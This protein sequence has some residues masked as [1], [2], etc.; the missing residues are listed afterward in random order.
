MAQFTV[1]RNKN[2]QTR[3]AIPFLLDIQN[4]LLDGLETRVVVPLYPLSAMK[5][6][7][8]R[9]LTPVLGIEGEPFVLLTPQMAGIPR[10]E[11]GDPVSRVEQHRF[12]IIAAIDFLVTGVGGNPFAHASQPHS[13]PKDPLPDVRLEAALGGNVDAAP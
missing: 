5:G 11:L 13:F 4:D 8:L 3:S 9:T 2:P 7:T 10:S 12:E 6:R 1:Y